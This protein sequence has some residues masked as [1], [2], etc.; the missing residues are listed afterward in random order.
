MSPIGA[1]PYPFGELS[2]S[3]GQASP[4][5]PGF[6]SSPTTPTPPVGPPPV[7]RRF[8]PS[9]I[10]YAG[11]LPD[12]VQLPRVVPRMIGPD[13]RTVRTDESLSSGQRSNPNHSLGS[14]FT[15]NEAER[16]GMQ[17]DLYGSG[18]THIVSP[19]ASGSSAGGSGDT[20]IVSPIASSGSG[21]GS[22][23]SVLLS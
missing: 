13:G 19:A 23:G 18:D 3:S 11:R 21:S 15:E 17:T 22:H 12:N 5:S 14:N 16:R 4:V 1:G 2:T 6:A 10:V 20:N 8:N 7:Y 9:N